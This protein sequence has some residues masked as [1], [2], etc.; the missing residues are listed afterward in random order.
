[1]YEIYK[2]DTPEIG[3]NALQVL[4]G[5]FKAKDQS[6]RALLIDQNILEFFIDVLNVSGVSDKQYVI[7]SLSFVLMDLRSTDLSKYEHFR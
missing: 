3:E 1:M 7:D 6:I 4:A 2:N 5:L